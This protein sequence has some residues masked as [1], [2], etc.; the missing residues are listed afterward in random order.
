MNTGQ[1]LLSIGALLLLSLTVLRVNNS[2]LTTDETLQDSKLGLLAVSVATSLIEEASKKAF[3]GVTAEDAITDLS[4][5]T[6]P[7]SLG[8]NG[9][10]T[11]ETF[12]DFDDYN[13]YTK[14][15]TINTIDY[16]IACQVNY[17]IADNVDGIIMERTWHKKITV[18]ITSSLMSDTLIFSSVYSYW[19]FR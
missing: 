3:D 10:E 14:Q 16:T 4:A 7:Y 8:P 9:L 19:H 1:S 6:S 18:I 2:I 5:L 13:G 11:P 17:I 15:D 12:N